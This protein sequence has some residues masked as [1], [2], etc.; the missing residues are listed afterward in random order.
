MQAQLW[1]GK[2]LD[3]NFLP[4]PN[5]SRI[6]SKQMNTRSRTNNFTALRTEMWLVLSQLCRVQ[7]KGATVY[8]SPLPLGCGNTTSSVCVIG[9][10]LFIDILNASGITLN[11]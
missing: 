2:D 10:T 9:P 3:I 11:L 8:G 5:D 6:A 4:V 1:R 7:I